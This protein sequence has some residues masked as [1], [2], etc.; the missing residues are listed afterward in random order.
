MPK[1]TIYSDGGSKPNPGAGGWAAILIS[2]DVEKEISGG[3]NHTSNN[4]MELMAAI[5]A[6]ES[7][8]EPCEVEF[9]TDSQYVKKGITEWI[10][11]WL[12][13][14]WMTSARKP[15]MNQELWERLHLAT[16]RHTIRWR[17]TRGHAGDV[18]N[19]RVDQLATQAR[20]SL[21]R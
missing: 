13:N 20:E 19:E 2:G 12:K 1:V 17:W 14:D 9:Y 21:R 4:K 16:Q 10:K 8:K 18:Y 5:S 3:E 6:L 11:N 15:V 7:L